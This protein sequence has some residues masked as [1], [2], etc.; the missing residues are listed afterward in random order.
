MRLVTLLRVSCSTFSVTLDWE[1]AATHGT[2]QSNQTN[3]YK[4]H[5]LEIAQLAGNDSL[6]ITPYTPLG[7]DY[8]YYLERER[9]QPVHIKP[10]DTVHLFIHSPQ[11]LKGAGYPS[12][13]SFP[14]DYENRTLHLV[15]FT[16]RSAYPA[17]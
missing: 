4:H 14:V 2:Q 1:N 15:R 6:Y 7:H 8:I 10:A 13:K 3:Q 5:A 12:L 17:E 16:G 9:N 11:A